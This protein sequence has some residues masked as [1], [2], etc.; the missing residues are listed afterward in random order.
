[1]VAV[2]LG[3]PQLSLSSVDGHPNLYELQ[4]LMS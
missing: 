2:C 4:V 3:F 1:M